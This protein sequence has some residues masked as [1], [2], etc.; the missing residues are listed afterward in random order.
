MENSYE[1]RIINL[2]KDD[3]LTDDVK[4]IE[5]G[6][7][8]LF[9]LVFLHNNKRIFVL[10]VK[11]NAVMTV[12]QLIKNWKTNESV[13]IIA[14]AF[15]VRFL[16]EIATYNCFDALFN[17]NYYF[18][19]LFTTMKHNITCLTIQENCLHQI[20]YFASNWKEFHE[21]FAIDGTYQQN[22]LFNVAEQFPDSIVIQY[23]VLNCIYKIKTTKFVSCNTECSFNNLLVRELMV[24]A[25][26]KFPEKTCDEKNDKCYFYPRLFCKTWIHFM[27]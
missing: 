4:I 24:K 5:N 11:L 2:L 22:A 25:L 19:I 23:L 21:Y 12:V 6:L 16:N 13:Q 15:M 17:N 14:S 7:T 3:L 9:D 1:R 18:E 10:I 20:L 8:T 27:D 26:E